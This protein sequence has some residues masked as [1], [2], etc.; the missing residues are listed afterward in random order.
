MQTL[1]RGFGQQHADMLDV[2][3]EVA[4]VQDRLAANKNCLAKHHSIVGARTAERSSDFQGVAVSK[5]RL[6]ELG[7]AVKLLP[8]SIVCLQEPK[9]YAVFRACP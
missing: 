5:I 9:T 3:Q 7:A 8:R 1:I 6:V 2:K 4:K